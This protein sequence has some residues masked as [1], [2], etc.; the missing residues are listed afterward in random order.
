MKMIKNIVLL[1]VLCSTTGM[2]AC[3]EKQPHPA[4]SPLKRLT[5]KFIMGTAGLG[6]IACGLLNL[7]RS[8]HIFALAYGNTS[9]TPEFYP[10]IH[11]ADTDPHSLLSN[12]INENVHALLGNET[13]DGTTDDN[14][15]TELYWIYSLSEGIDQ[16]KKAKNL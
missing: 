2:V 10:D 6:K 14:S 8:L 15:S 5:Q 7:P 12:D 16:L 9:E 11:Q 1:A 4:S 3:S 13:N